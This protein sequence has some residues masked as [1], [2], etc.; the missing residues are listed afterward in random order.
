MLEIDMYPVT[1]QALHHSLRPTDRKALTSHSTSTMGLIPDK[2]P[3]GR[4]AM[5]CWTLAQIQL[6]TKVLPHHCVQL[7]M[8]A[9]VWCT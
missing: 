8:D 4:P 1:T 7:A 9:T 6:L 2:L 3:F 5:F